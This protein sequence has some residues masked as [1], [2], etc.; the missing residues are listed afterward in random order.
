MKPKL[1]FHVCCAPCSGLLS[2]QLKENYNISVYFANS[3]I[4]PL[5]EFYKRAQEAEK[6]FNSEGV[7]FVLADW[8]HNQWLELIQGLEQE[9]ERGKRCQLCYYYRLKQAAQYAVFH[10]FDCFTTS[11]SFSPY[12]DQKVILNLGRVLGDEYKIK[13]IDS[14]FRANDNWRY[15]CLFSKEQGFYRQKYCGC[16]FSINN[17]KI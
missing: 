7:E 11:L 2:R 16:E 3:N 14:D 12:K 4:W 13:F 5:E 8:N 10:N 6:F 17:V 9:P 1:L 15:A